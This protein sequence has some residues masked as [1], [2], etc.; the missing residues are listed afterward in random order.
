MRYIFPIAGR[1]SR[2][3]AKADENPE[4]KKPKPL[5]DVLGVPMIKRAVEGFEIQEKDS[6]IFI[7]RKE[8]IDEFQ[9][10]KLLKDLFGE[11]T[12]IIIQDTLPEGAAKTVLL[13]KEHINNGESILIT[14]SDFILEGDKYISEIK[15]QN[16]DFALPVFYS[17]NPRSSFAK[18]D[19]EGIVIETAEKNPISTNAIIG[20]YYFG[21]GSDF[22]YACEKMIAEENK[23]GNEF[24]IS[25]MFNYLIQKGKKGIIVKDCELIEMG[26]P[27]LLEKSFPEIKEKDIL[28]T[29]K[30][31]SIKAGKFIMQDYGKGNYKIKEV[32]EHYQGFDKIKKSFVTDIDIGAQK[33]ILERL[34]KF[35]EYS[36]F[37]EESDYEINDLLEEFNPNSEF[38]F[39]IDPLDGTGNYLLGNPEI[40]KK[41]SQ[42]YLEENEE[43][44]PDNSDKFGVCI[45]LTKNSVPILSVIYYPKLESI[46]YCQKGKGVFI[47]G[48]RIEISQKEEHEFSDAIRISQY[49]KINEFKEKFSNR[50]SYQSASYNLRALIKE[51]IISYCIESVDYLDFCSALL[52]YEEAG[53]FIGDEK[54]KK[55]NIK[56]LVENVDEKCRINQF[57]ILCPTQ[58][59]CKSLLDNL[60]LGLN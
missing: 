51:N 42:A 56:K 25:P 41:L 17:E 40:M 54:G 1:G 37:A 7:V 22:V 47:D 26:T 44:M 36:I 30:E 33:I 2:F 3:L 55:I 59:Y 18:V 32:P 12:I 31:A 35:K 10:D 28:E 34:L 5:I 46:M 9:I 16:P 20:S 15:K 24:Y 57:M 13:A 6:L 39:V 8:H 19:E 48:E 49:S 21:K 14:D 29:M 58:E 43:E 45:S 38:K 11:K 23:F 60:N 27:E 52:M 50:K 53:G 4:Y